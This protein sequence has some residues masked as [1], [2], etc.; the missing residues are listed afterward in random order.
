MSG[1]PEQKPSQPGSDKQISIC[2]SFFCPTCFCQLFSGKKME[3][4]KM[5]AREKKDARYGQEQESF[6]DHAQRSSGVVSIAV[7][8]A[9]SLF[10]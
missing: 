6:L 9:I 8:R 3:G 2:S 1:T 7:L 4:K 10:P 5:K